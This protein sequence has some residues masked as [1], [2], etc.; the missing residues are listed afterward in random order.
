MKLEESYIDDLVSRVIEITEEYFQSVNHD[1]EFIVNHHISKRINNKNGKQFIS[2]QNY[3]FETLNNDK[4]YNKD[5]LRNFKKMYSLQGL[6]HIHIDELYNEP[7]IDLIRNEKLTEL[8]SKMTKYK[9]YGSFFTKLV[10]TFNPENYCPIDNPIRDYFKLGHESF[11]ITLIVISRAYKGWANN[12]RDFMN[13]LRDA[14]TDIFKKNEI[15]LKNNRISDMK[16]LNLV[17]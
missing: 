1:V 12:N 10:H 16:I 17:F 11:F 8:Y 2:F 13:E 3:Y 15:D 9:H 7:I 4:A 5:F 14:I 6:L